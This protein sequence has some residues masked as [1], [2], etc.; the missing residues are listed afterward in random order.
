MY[1]T[2]LTRYPGSVFIEESR[3]KYRAL[4]LIYPDKEPEPEMN[5]EDVFFKGVEEN[6]FE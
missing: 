3:E 6:E 1:K 2:I 4:R 5:N